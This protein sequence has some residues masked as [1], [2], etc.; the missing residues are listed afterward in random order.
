MTTFDCAPDCIG[1]LGKLHDESAIGEHCGG[2]S[3]RH[4]DDPDRVELLEGCKKAAVG[5]SERQ[6]D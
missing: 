3:R 2:A 6:N 4:R 5:G 1:V